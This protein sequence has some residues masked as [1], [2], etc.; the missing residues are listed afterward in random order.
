MSAN[1]AKLMSDLTVSLGVT[2]QQLGVVLAL[3]ALAWLVAILSTRQQ[4]VEQFRSRLRHGVIDARLELEEL[5]LH[6]IQVL[7]NALNSEQD[8]EVLAAIDIFDSHGQTDRMPVLVLY[9][10]SKSVRRR[11][12]EA[13]VQRHPHHAP[14]R[15]ALFRLSSAARPGH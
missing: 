14:A 4:Y 5:D 3:L 9:H 6:S 7:S 2:T 1:Q 8:E 12:L 13:F 15:D 10:P 11:A